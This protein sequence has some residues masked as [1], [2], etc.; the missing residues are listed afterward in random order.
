MTK[1]STNEV[2]SVPVGE[3]GYYSEFVLGDSSAFIKTK[4]SPVK[5]HYTQVELAK[6]TNKFEPEQAKQQQ[7]RKHISL[8]E[9]L[10]PETQ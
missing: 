5:K 4:F 3:A 1:K 9:L 10:N 7:G 6:A 2:H 8:K